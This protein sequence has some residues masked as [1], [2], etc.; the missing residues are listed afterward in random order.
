MLTTTQRGTVGEQL[1]SACVTL[2]SDGD[3]ELFKPL[4][5]DDHTDI[6][7]GRRGMVPALAIQVKTALTLNPK[8]VAVARMAFPEGKPRVHPAFVYGIVFVPD[9]SVEA[10]WIIPSVDFNRLAYRGPAG[11]ARASSC[12]SWRA[13]SATTAGRSS[14][15]AGWSWERG[16]AP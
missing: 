5:D 13:R 7:V 16:S 9:A 4:T 15:A 10:A 8:K 12:S 14:A 6:T 11:A 1:F 2:S 3:L